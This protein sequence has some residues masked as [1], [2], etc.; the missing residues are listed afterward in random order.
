MYGVLGAL[1]L[2]TFSASLALA[3]GDCKLLPQS[4]DL[5]F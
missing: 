4:A 1:A 2:C 3:A 5:L